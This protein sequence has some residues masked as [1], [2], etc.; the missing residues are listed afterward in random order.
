MYVPP[1]VQVTPQT[2]GSIAGAR[3]S[4]GAPA[5]VPVTAACVLKGTAWG[6]SLDGYEGGIQHADIVG[7]VAG[8]TTGA[9]FS[10]DNTVGG[11]SGTLSVY[12]CS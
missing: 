11:R 12:R 9:T 10:A 4:L 6:T 3:A 1:V 7:M 8:N 5:F 2:L